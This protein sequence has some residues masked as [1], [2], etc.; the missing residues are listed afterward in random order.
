M[1]TGLTSHPFCLSLEAPTGSLVS[2]HTQLLV[3]YALTFAFLHR[4]LCPQF[5]PWLLP[6]HQLSVSSDATFSQRA[7]PVKQSP[8]H[9]PSHQ[10]TLLC[11]SQSC[12]PETMAFSYMFL[13]LL[14]ASPRHSMGA[15]ASSA[16]LGPRHRH[17]VR[18]RI[19]RR[20]RKCHSS[21]AS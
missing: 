9:P 11:V 17:Q 13:H 5:F 7:P 15:G 2:E 10:S 1:P 16:C 12:W 8:P 21:Q 18:K 14:L 6:P 3:F 20:L 4:I 19:T